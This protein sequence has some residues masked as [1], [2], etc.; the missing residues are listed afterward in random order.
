MKTGISSALAYHLARIVVRYVTT[1]P[2][3]LKHESQA[4]RD[5]RPDTFCNHEARHIDTRRATALKSGS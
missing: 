5:A 4:T 1:V 2:R 3:S